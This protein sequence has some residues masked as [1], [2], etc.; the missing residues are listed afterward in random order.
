MTAV[1]FLF[2]IGVVAG[3][4]VIFTLFAGSMILL[5]KTFK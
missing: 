2:V 1:E 3:I 4:G 5:T